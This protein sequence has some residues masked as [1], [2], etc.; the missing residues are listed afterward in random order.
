MT[1]QELID[2]LE[3]IEDKNITV[4]VVDYFNGHGE[5]WDEVS[6]VYEHTFSDGEK[7]LVID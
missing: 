2:R 3:R 6:A 5:G 4:N 7:L 1:V